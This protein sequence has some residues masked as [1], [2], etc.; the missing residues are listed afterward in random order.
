[1]PATIL[2][3]RC[4]S[5]GDHVLSAC[6]LPPLRRT[7]PDARIIAVVPDSV[8]PLYERC[9]LINERVGISFRLFGNPAFRANITAQ[10]QSFKAD[11]CLSPVYSRTEPADILVGLSHAS[12]RIGHAGDVRRIRPERREL[13]N[14]IYTRLIPC[15]SPWKLE[16]ARHADFLAGIGVPFL[17]AEIQPKIWTHP[18]DDEFAAAIFQQHGLDPRQTVVMFAGAQLGV[19]KYR[20]YGQAIAPICRDRGLKV[21]ALGGSEDS[22]INQ[23]NLN[24]TG[25]PGIN[26]SGKTTLRQAAAVLRLCRICIGAETGL[27]HIA[28]AVGTPNVVLLGGGHFGRFMPY[29]P[30]TTVA[31][32]PLSCFGCDWEC[33]FD[34]VHCTWDLAP[35]VLTAAFAHALDH[36][37]TDRIDVF[38]QSA[39]AWPNAEPSVKWPE[40]LVGQLPLNRWQVDRNGV[41]SLHSP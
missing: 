34:R 13:N 30:L 23:T 11:L 37:A 36:S 1:M 9:P 6:M 17:P 7:F 10:L 28:C 33:R 2:Y 35:Q 21:L 15:T 8:A 4:D 3:L 41:A 18:A 16:L 25:T 12:Q 19:R 20:F 32:V 22:A 24:D 29:S 31:C 38:C 5:I 27:A 26:L 40:S 14:R 39:D